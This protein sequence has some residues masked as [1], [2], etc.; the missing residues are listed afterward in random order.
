MAM[1]ILVAA[2]LIWAS[3]SSVFHPRIPA[4]WRAWPLAGVTAWRNL[5]SR[6]RAIPARRS[7]PLTAALLVAT[8]MASAPSSG[9][10]HQGLAL[11][12]IVTL[13]FNVGFWY[14]NHGPEAAQHQ[15]PSGA[16]GTA[17]CPEIQESMLSLTMVI[18][19]MLIF[20]KFFT[21]IASINGSYYTFLSDPGLRC[22]RAELAQV[23]L[24]FF[25]GAVAV[26]TLVRCRPLGDRIGR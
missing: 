4:G 20:S 5:Y 10:S 15:E 7:S 2:M 17:A 22:I 23:H 3:S 6:L 12:G 8:C 13:Q 25:L 11:L 9:I 14:K 21:I 1:V 19:L 24:F 18:L 16:S 26:G